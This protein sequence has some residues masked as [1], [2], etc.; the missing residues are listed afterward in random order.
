MRMLPVGPSA[1]CTGW[2]SGEIAS[3]KFEQH[4]ERKSTLSVGGFFFFT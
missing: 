3:V 4:Q 2:M 1:P